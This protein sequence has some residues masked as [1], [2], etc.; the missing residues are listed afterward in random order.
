MV[1]AI[2]VRAKQRYKR[3]AKRRPGVLRS[4]SHEEVDTGGRRGRVPCRALHGFHGV[5][6]SAAE[7]NA[8]AC[9]RPAASAQSLPGAVQRQRA[10]SAPWAR[11]KWCMWGCM[12]A[13]V[14]CERMRVFWV[15]VKPLRSQSTYCCTLRYNRCSSLRRSL[16][17]Y[18]FRCRAHR[19]SKTGRRMVLWHEHLHFA[20][21]CYAELS[22]VPP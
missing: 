4:R 18:C 20:S 11:E 6:T 3:E 9:C 16:L 13:T 15:A 14:S 2:A 22:P 10:A 17:F 5:T 7:R 8:S 19:L 21:P 12:G 1:R